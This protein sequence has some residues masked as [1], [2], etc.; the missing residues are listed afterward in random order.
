MTCTPRS[1]T[2]AARTRLTEGEVRDVEAW[3]KENLPVLSEG[4]LTAT[5]ALMLRWLK[6]WAE[7][8]YASGE[9]KA[10]FGG[11]TVLEMRTAFRVETI[12]EIRD[13]M[14]SAAEKGIFDSL[15]GTEFPVVFSEDLDD[16]SGPEQPEQD[17]LHPNAWADPQSRLVNELLVRGLSDSQDRLAW[18]LL[19][20]IMKR[21]TLRILLDIADYRAILD[22]AQEDGPTSVNE[23]AQWPNPGSVYIELSE[24]LSEDPEGY[25]GRVDGFIIREDSGALAR[26]FVIPSIRQGSLEAI[27]VGFNL[28]TEEVTGDNGRRIHGRPIA[29]L[30]REIAAFLT[31]ESTEFVAMPTN[32]KMK[33]Q[34]RR[35]GTT[36]PWHVVQRRRRPR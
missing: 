24:A 18:K 8:E 17:C 21:N 19:Y 20:Q 14:K 33:R 16:E 3:T 29:E 1:P 15:A 32:R 23:D 30:I 5:E 10:A 11:D 4:E 7:T 28:R 9:L 27:G 36:N 2:I 35:S 34:M 12:A 6:Y 22:R 25:T 13:V 26:G 31:D